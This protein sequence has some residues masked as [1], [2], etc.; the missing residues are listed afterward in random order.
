MLSN[1]FALDSLYSKFI[2][3]LFVYNSLKIET[4]IK[5]SRKPLKE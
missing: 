4:K 5:A 2:V 1:L 3:V